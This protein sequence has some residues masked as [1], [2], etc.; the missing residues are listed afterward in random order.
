MIDESAYGEILDRLLPSKDRQRHRGIIL[1]V[2]SISTR[3]DSSNPGFLPVTLMVIDEEDIEELTEGLPMQKITKH[4]IVRIIQEVHLGRSGLL[5]MRDIELLTW[6]YGSC[7]SQHRK[8][9]EKN[10]FAL[11]YRGSL[12]DMGSYALH[13]SCWG[14]RFYDLLQGGSAQ[15]PG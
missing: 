7:N 4:A 12:E 15:S 8:K 10:N 13:K 2:V 14:R 6:H 5:S 1:N 11:P 3:A 9:Y